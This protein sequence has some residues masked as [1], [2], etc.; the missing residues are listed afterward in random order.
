MNQKKFNNTMNFGDSNHMN[1][2]NSY[3]MSGQPDNKA[4][5]KIGNYQYRSTQGQQIKF[6]RVGGSTSVGANTPSHMQHQILMNRTGPVKLRGN[7]GAVKDNLNISGYSN[8]EE[9]KVK[10]QLVLQGNQ[11]QKNIAWSA[12]RNSSVKPRGNRPQTNSGSEANIHVGGRGSH[13]DGVMR[14]GTAPKQ[15]MMN[16]FSHVRGQE[17][18]ISP[19]SK[20]YGN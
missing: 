14:P 15:A 9:K 7:S 16:N 13:Q 6:G 1:E 5:G 3:F 8:N 2:I 17:R 4:Q 11:D 20:V 18:P 12:Q 10:R 19:Y